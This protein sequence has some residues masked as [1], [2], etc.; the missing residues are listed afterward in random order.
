VLVIIGVLG[1]GSGSKGERIY[2]WARFAL[3]PE[4]DSD[5]GHHHLL[6]RRNDATGEPAYLRCYTPYPVMLRTLVRVAGQ[7]WRI[8][9]SFQAAKS[10]TG[11]K[12]MCRCRSNRPDRHPA[13]SEARA[14]PVS[15]V[16]VTY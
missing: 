2:S 7:R 5:T 4:D 16:I 10:L 3:R 15:F 6:I 14:I 8:E 1:V 11:L 9:E 12:V 13:T